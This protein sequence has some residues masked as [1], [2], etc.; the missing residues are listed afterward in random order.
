[1]FAN[2]AIYHDGWIAATTPPEPPWLLGTAKLPGDVINGYKWELYNISKDY[3]EANDLAP[4]MPDKLRDLQQLFLVEADK[5]GVFPI[6]NSVLE[7]V[8]A[9][10]P[11][12]TAG[13]TTFSYSG[14]LSGIPE[15]D[16]PSILNR[17]YTITAEVEV[18]QGSAEGMLVTDGGR[19][20]GYGLYLLKGKPVFTY[21][22]ADLERFRWEGQQE[23]SPGKHTIEFDFTY[24]GPGFGK[25]GTGVL[26][27]DGAAVATKSV[28]HT[29]PILMTIDETFDVGV[30]TRTPVDDRDYQVPFRFTGK[31]T[32]LTFKLG[33]VRL[34]E[35]ERR[36]MHAYLLRAKD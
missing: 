34:S 28:P 35:L 13:R 10:R 5:Y 18:P 26:K 16:A 15:S 11:S 29:T 9:P 12:A 23:L 25:G 17:S 8:I 21:N 24:Q 20:G 4:Q 22:L 14:E 32:N 27:V 19:F 31:L 3:S 7:R 2:R 6:D 1:M 30:D 33:P 36:E